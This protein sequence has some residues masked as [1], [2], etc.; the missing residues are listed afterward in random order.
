LD[1]G[2]PIWSARERGEPMIEAAVENK[3]DFNMQVSLPAMAVPSR[4]SLPSPIAMRRS[5]LI[6]LFNRLRQISGRCRA[7]S[8][9]DDRG[10]KPPISHNRYRSRD[11]HSAPGDSVMDQAMRSSAIV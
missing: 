2:N 4:S 11:A 1:K 5:T 3:Y 10:D 9:T 7:T 8:A 6:K